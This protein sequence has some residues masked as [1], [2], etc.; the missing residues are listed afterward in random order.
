MVSALKGLENLQARLL[1]I[2]EEVKVGAKELTETEKGVMYVVVGQALGA[3]AQMEEELVVIVEIL[4]LGPGDGKAGVIMYSIINFNVWLTVI[5]DLYTQEP[6]LASLKP[7]WNKISAR[8]RKIKDVRDRLAHEPTHLEK[9]IMPG[10]H[11]TPS[12][13]PSKFDV[14]PK[15]RKYAPLI[16]TEIM[17]FTMAVASISFDLV[18]L[19]N[20][21]MSALKSSHEKSPG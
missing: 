2:K 3:W 10:R 8:I 21:M 1:S 7:R 11:A 9:G 18:V 6:R 5:N 4:L 12:L 16:S 17:D 20:D 13:R 19:A 15:T 14:R